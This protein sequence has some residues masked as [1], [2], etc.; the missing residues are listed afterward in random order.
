M[1][2]ALLGPTKTARLSSIAMSHLQL[3][4]IL[5]ALGLVT[6]ALT[7]YCTTW[8]LVL[9]PLCCLSLAVCAYVGSCCKRRDARRG[10]QGKPDSTAIVML[11]SEQ[12][13]RCSFVAC[14]S[15]MWG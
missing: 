13:S 2:N 1:L 10:L 14:A 7:V 3:F 15:E 12:R 4:Y 5:P 9:L 6:K 8:Q 11:E